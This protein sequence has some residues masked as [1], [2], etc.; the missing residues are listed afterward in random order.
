MSKDGCT[1]SRQLANDF[2]FEIRS[3]RRDGQYRWQLSRAI[4]QRDENGKI[5]M[6][7]GT[8]TDIQE[9]K[10]F[11]SELEKQVRKRTK[12]LAE[13]NIE[14][15]KMNKELQSFAYISSHDLQEPLRKIQ[16]FASRMAETEKEKLS[17]KG[18]DHLKRMQASAL[19]M[20]TLIE[21]LLS[22]SRTNT[23]ERKFEGTDLIKSLTRLQRS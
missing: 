12:E 13:N 20:Q 3:L 16:T 11:T 19:R 7:V 14:L 18:K 2:L 23:S 9:Q 17:E 1:P 8:S 4:P 6:W 21:D 22:Y 15:E 10:T 5:Q